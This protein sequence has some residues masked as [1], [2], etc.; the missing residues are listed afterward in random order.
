MYHSETQRFYLYLGGRNHLTK[1]QNRPITG[2][3]ENAFLAHFGPI[4]HFGPF[5]G[6][7][8]AVFWGG[9]NFMVTRHHRRWPQTNFIFYSFSFPSHVLIFLVSLH[10]V[11]F[12]YVMLS[13]LFLCLYI[14]SV[15]TIIVD[16]VSLISMTQC[17]MEVRILSG[18]VPKNLTL[19]GMS[20]T[21]FQPFIFNPQMP[22]HDE[23]SRSRKFSWELG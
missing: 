7:F 5:S 11:S 9:S 1:F 4:S 14:S 23:I 18:G 13:T 6:R 19:H 3:W 15:S 12:K 21:E 17:K 2:F 22:E 8:W 16:Y 20:K 10:I